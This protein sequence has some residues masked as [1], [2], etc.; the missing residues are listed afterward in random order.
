MPAPLVGRAPVM[1]GAHSSAD[2]L[3][4]EFAASGNP[5]ALGE[6]YDLVAP[7]LLRV[8]LHATRDAADA[9]DVLQATFVAAIERAASFDRT[10]R[11][12]PWLVGILANEARKARERAARRPDPERLERATPGDPALEAERT[13]LLA[14]LDSA[15]ERVPAAFRPVLTLRLRHGLSVPE[16]A[17]ALER[18]SGTVRSQLARGTEC[19]RRALPA[20]LAG[21]LLVV[22]TPTRGLAAVRAAVVEHAVALHAPLSLVTL[23]GGL[24]AVKKLV[25]VSVALLAA[26]VWWG[27]QRVERAPAGNSVAVAE[28]PPV[29]L[30]APRE[31]APVAAEAEPAREELSVAP[32]PQAHAP[33]AAELLGRLLVHVRGPDGAPAPGELVLLTP[34]GGRNDDPLVGTADERGEARFDTLAPGSWYV[35]L[36]RG[37]EDQGNVRAGHECELTLALF[38]GVTVEGRVLD[39][40]GEPVPAA[41]VWLSERYRPN[42]GHVVARAD[43]QGA[44][45]LRQVGPDHWL[46]A[47][48]NGFAPSALRGVRGGAGDRVSLVLRLVASASELHGRVLDERG[49]PIAEA[50]VLV[51]AEDIVW[52]RQDEG[53][54]DPAAPAQRVSTD[55]DGRFAL[56]SAPLG[57]QPLQVRAN[58]FATLASSFEVLDG[59]P[60]ECTLVLAR[61]ARVVGR[62]RGPDGQP[63]ASTWIRCGEAER[64][65]SVSTWSG[66]DGRFA[67]GQLGG[68]VRLLAR[69]QQYGEAERELTLHPGETAEWE[70]ALAPTPTLTGQ[71]LDAHGAPLADHVVVLVAPDDRAQR[72]RSEAS[73]ADG[74]FALSG[75]E[76]RAYT[77]WVQPKHGW[78]GF[79]E[80]ELAEVW[81]DG[82]PLV[83]RVPDALESARITA[84]VT[85]SEGAPLAGAEL[86]VW[87]EERK[88]WR[89][90]VSAGE[91]GA[92]VVEGVPPGTL[93]LELRHPD[94]PWKHIGA[95]TLVPGET[96]DL[97]RLAFEPSGRLRVP[98][99]GLA[100]ERMAALTTWI[101]DASEHEGGVARVGGGELT[102]GAL[103]P[104]RHTLIVSGEG[105]RQV[106]REFVIEEGHETSFALVLE[107]CGVRSVAF[108]FPPEAPAPKW[109]ACSLFDAQGALIWAGNADCASAPPL[110]RV[111]APPGSYTLVVSAAGELSG[112]FEL[113]LASLGDDEPALHLSLA[114]QP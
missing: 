78:N 47:R 113:T 98:L 16:I 22:A 27:V 21:A 20:G 3:F 73:G 87:H 99:S 77:L 49:A 110:A 1:D 101:A 112:R 32:V 36:L 104:G 80:L 45:T 55:A 60:N 83:L 13:E 38:D 75:L 11:V 66:L 108:G 63:L 76:R 17:A 72:T 59:A 86:Q 92:L 51:G 105:V 111:S 52:V 24:F 84:E 95:R 74:R 35:R 8:A 107:R 93:E 82:A 4:R 2:R 18:P 23:A 44:F 62:V 29:A 90:F 30:E 9:E 40:R 103:A 71:L 65:A 97:G 34:P 53:G 109:I 68:R 88:L 5:R 58:G 102:S 54:S 42:L 43:A 6:V 85:T 50:D 25:V 106:R 89:A 96:L 12:L 91:H 56:A 114:R 28:N 41:D 7:E 70:V 19:L 64:F 100:E 33:A 79:P 46:G 37:R 10:Q 39:A 69:H 14:Q 67:L 15:L 61:E 57:L 48:K 81:P 94:H 26:L 31:R